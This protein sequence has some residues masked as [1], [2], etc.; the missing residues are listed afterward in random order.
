MLETGETEQA[1]QVTI[2]IRYFSHLKT[3]LVL[4]IF[5]STKNMKKPIYFLIYLSIR[6]IYAFFSVSTQ[7]AKF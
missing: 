3:S 4:R 1:K 2:A 5:Y 7:T 6:P